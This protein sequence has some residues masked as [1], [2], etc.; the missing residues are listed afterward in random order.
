MDAGA[1]GTMTVRLKDIAQDLGVSTVTV[2]KVLR[3]KS[4]IGE[5]TR[6]RVLKR[7]QELNYQPNLLARGLASGRSH[8]IGL[9]VPDLVHPFFADFA[10]SLASVLR[11]SEHALILASSEEDRDIE[12]REVMALARRGVDVLL[13]AS[14]H[15]AGSHAPELTK[16]R[17]PCLL[18]DRNLPRSRLNFVGSNDVRAGELA[19]EHLVG[20]GRK[21]IAHIGGAETS[22][23]IDRA[24]GFAAALTRLKI[25]L[26]PAYVV[27]NHHIEEAGDAVG[28]AAMQRLLKLKRKPDAVFCYNDLSAVGAIDAILKA[29]LRVPEDIAVIGCGNF[30]YADYLKVPLSSIDQKTAALGRVAGELALTLTTQPACAPQTILLEPSLVLRAS[31]IPA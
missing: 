31:T 29:G 17:I 9:I 1:A 25:K 23:S 8:T 30:R 7:M 10:R 5:E 20:L 27:R 15:P 3:G 13:V 21:R 22:P 26:P 24:R 2:S 11:A 18:V 28:F 12:A 6:Q 16:A 14:C 19:A 4:D